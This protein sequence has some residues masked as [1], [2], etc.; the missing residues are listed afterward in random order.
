[1]AKP[2]PGLHRAMREVSSVSGRN[3]VNKQNHLHKMSSKAYSPVASKG[4]GQT[5]K[6][7]TFPLPTSFLAFVQINYERSKVTD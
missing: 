3:R 4:S 1:M 5:E 2:F 6:S 7:G